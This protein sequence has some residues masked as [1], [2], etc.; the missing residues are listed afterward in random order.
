[1]FF[2]LEDHNKNDY[3]LLY[4]RMFKL[5]KEIFADQLG[6]DVK[7]SDLGEVDVYDDCNPAYLVWSNTEKTILY[8]CLRLLPTTG[9]TLLYDVFRDTFPNNVSLTAPGIWEG[10][11]LCIDEKA[12]ANDHPDMGA[13]RAFCLMLLGLC[14]VALQFN[15]HTLISNYEPAS[16]RLYNMSGAE[17]VELGRADQYGRRPVCAGSFEVS[18]K[19]LQNMR[20]RLG[21]SHALLNNDFSNDLKK[22][23]EPQAA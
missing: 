7:L 13:K 20:I 23:D 14:E 6:W 8:G 12:L 1:M 3:P 10:T 11:R 9:P 17:L 5:R 22:T 18:K 16:K 4:Q 19:V 21:V 2:V 15:I